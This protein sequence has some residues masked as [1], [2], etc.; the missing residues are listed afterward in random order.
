M[1]VA[2]VG[3]LVGHHGSSLLIVEELEQPGGDDDAP[4]PRHG[5][6][7]GVCVHY[8]V[9]D[10]YDLAAATRRQLGMSANDIAELTGQAPELAVQPEGEPRREHQRES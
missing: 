10:D 2:K 1:A 8:F 6:R 5:A 4:A 9:T 3:A 7:N